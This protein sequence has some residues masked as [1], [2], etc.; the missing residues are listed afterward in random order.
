MVSIMSTFQ[1]IA[2]EC[3][4]DLPA[5]RNPLTPSEHFAQKI[6]RRACS[7]WDYLGDSDSKSTELLACEARLIFLDAMLA[8]EANA[9]ESSAGIDRFL[10]E[11]GFFSPEAVKSFAEQ[12][13][14]RAS[15]VSRAKDA[16]FGCAAVYG[17]FLGYAADMPE[18][19]G[20]PDLNSFE[21][22]VD[23]VLAVQDKSY[24]ESSENDPYGTFK[25]F[26]Q[27]TA[28]TRRNQLAQ[29][30]FYGK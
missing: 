11:E 4:G 25:F 12:T 8:H 24:L 17:R 13:W 16:V 14:T 21:I 26:F 6:L 22:Y 15:K 27:I 29:S 1:A 10:A 7:L 5:I 28:Q 18:A 20:K 3:F 2:S 23:R 9:D 30:G 19:F